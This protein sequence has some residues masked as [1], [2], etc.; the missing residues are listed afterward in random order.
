VDIIKENAPFFITS[1]TGAVFIAPGRILCLS[2]SIASSLDITMPPLNA[3]LVARLIIEQLGLPIE[4]WTYYQS[5]SQLMLPASDGRAIDGAEAFGQHYIEN[6]MAVII[7][8][9]KCCKGWT[10]W[11]LVKRLS[12][13]GSAGEEETHEFAMPMNIAET[14][15]MPRYQLPQ[16]LQRIRSI[17][18]TPLWKDPTLIN[19]AIREVWDRYRIQQDPQRVVNP[20]ISSKS[21][22]HWD[23]LTLYDSSLKQKNVAMHH[24]ALNY[25]HLTPIERHIVNGLDG[26]TKPKIKVG[27]TISTL[28]DYCSYITYAQHNKSVVPGIHHMQYLLLLERLARHLRC[29]PNL[30]H[31]LVDKMDESIVISDANL[32]TLD[33][34]LISHEK[35]SKSSATIISSTMLKKTSLYRSSDRVEKQYHC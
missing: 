26:I 18:P 21:R 34:D 15:I 3:P 30:L 23:H 4:V 14:S 10:R 7:I 31:L 8:A 16:L 35:S 12:S 9:C 25:D 28:K 20:S 24:T 17:V 32:T 5:L 13:G 6:I 29:A 22:L 27:F 2:E 11:A 1:V 19:D 33:G